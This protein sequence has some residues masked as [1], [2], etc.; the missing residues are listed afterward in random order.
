MATSSKESALVASLA[1]FALVMVA[2]AAQAATRDTAYSEHGDP[3]RW[4]VPADTPR[5]KF[6]N[7]AREARNALAE[8]IRECRAGRDRKR[9]EAQARAQYR[10]DMARAREYLA[11][12]RQL[13]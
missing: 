5:A 9:C 8:Q 13:A 11:P 12:N 3:H 4:Y 7:A 10:G 2:G 1:A 6:D